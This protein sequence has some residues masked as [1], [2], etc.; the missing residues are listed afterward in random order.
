VSGG[1]GIVLVLE[2]FA[3][4]NGSRTLLRRLLLDLR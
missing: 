3:S 2:F 4:L 1:E